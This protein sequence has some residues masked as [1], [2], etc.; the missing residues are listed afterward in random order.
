MTTSSGWFEC[1]P[2]SFLANVPAAKKR[3]RKDWYIVI[4]VDG[5]LKGKVKE[6]SKKVK[7]R[8]R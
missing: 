7:K 4:I 3:S 8:G 5:G 6:C 2:N 1:A